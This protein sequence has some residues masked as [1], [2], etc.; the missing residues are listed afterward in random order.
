[1][2]VVAPMSDD[3][4]NPGDK[5]VYL[6][7]DD[8]PGPYT[9]KLLDILD[10]YNV[11]ATFFV[12]NGKP[13]YQN[14]IAQEAQ[15]GHTVAIHSASHDYA[16]IYQSVDAYFADFD[17]M[18]SIITAQTGKA[19]D[20]VRFPGGSS[21]TISKTYCYG[22]M[23]QL[24]CAV[25]ERGFRYCDWNVSSGDA[26]GTTSTSQVVAN[27]IAGIKDNNV[28][29][30]LQHDIKNFSVDA[31]METDNTAVKANNISTLLF[32]IISSLE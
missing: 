10:R 9:E 26:G 13:D 7:F 6:T 30:V 28:S 31:V 32:F 5:V 18:N 16:K 23:S 12:T 8:G 17:E 15:R 11:K 29:V 24:V 20:L 4:V 22:I 21:N 3:A 2:K 14:L 1:M 25:E 27:V 19:A